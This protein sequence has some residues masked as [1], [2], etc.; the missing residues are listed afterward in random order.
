M[1]HRRLHSRVV[2]ERRLLVGP[3]RRRVRV[4][5]VLLSPLSQSCDGSRTWML[6]T[7]LAPRKGIL[8][9]SY[10]GILDIDGAYY[11]PA[12]AC[13]ASLA[14]QFYRPIAS[15]KNCPVIPIALLERAQRS[16]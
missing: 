11:H 12:V 15:E 2:R 16:R 5:V 7:L 6:L 8:H 14:G 4:L 10:I 13:V 3:V 1:C 9:R